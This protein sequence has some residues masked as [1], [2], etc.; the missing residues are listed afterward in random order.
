MKELYTLVA[1]IGVLGLLYALKYMIDLAKEKKKEVEDKRVG[2]VFDRVTDFAETAVKKADEKIVKVI[3]ESPDKIWDKKTQREVFEGVLETIKSW[4]SSEQMNT[5]EMYL[6]SSEKV[7]GY[8][9]EKIESEVNSNKKSGG[10]SK[11]DSAK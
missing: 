5:L 9:G 2:Y 11:T 10:N 8:I 7:D 6:G 1:I 3:K 4:L